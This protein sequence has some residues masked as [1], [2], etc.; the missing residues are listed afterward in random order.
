MG[1]V[2]DPVEF[3]AHLKHKAGLHPRFWDE[4]VRLYRYTVSKWKEGDLERL[5]E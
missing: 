4:G 1:T 3:L 5:S 2:A